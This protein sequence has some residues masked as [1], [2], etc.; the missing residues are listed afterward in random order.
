MPAAD[1]LAALKGVHGGGGKWTVRCP[2]HN[3]HKPSLS[4][5]LGDDG[6]VLLK[7]F[8]GCSVEE[9]VGAVGLKMKD[10]FPPTSSR[11]LSFAAPVS[12]LGSIVAEYDYR[13]ER[14]DLLYQATRHQPKDF[15]VRRPDA[16]G[17]WMWGLGRVRRVVYRLPELLVAK[18]E[19]RGIVFVE[20]EKDCDAL[21]AL[22]MAATT[23]QGGASAP[24]P[25]DIATVLGG[26]KLA[27]L[28][29]HDA[30][31]RTFA[32]RVAKAVD[33]RAAT[34]TIVNLPGLGDKEDVSDWLSRGG[35]R[36][37]LNALIKSAPHYQSSSVR[38]V[39]AAVRKPRPFALLRPTRAPHWGTAP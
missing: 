11:S 8:S 23:V 4:I 24:L 5:S 35:T 32:E 28:P 37:K 15:R 17:G 22:G 33:G 20:G 16:Q 36:K 19:G 12:T 14:G 21:V 27:I 13:D 39:R 31:G 1:F 3:D 18:A 2:A 34:V 7:C 38:D 30:P 25:G 10:H 6:R 9:V 29:D 26:V